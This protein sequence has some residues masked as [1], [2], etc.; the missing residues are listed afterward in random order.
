MPVV[1]ESHIGIEM[2]FFYRSYKE[3]MIFCPLFVEIKGIRELFY[4]L[5]T[6]KSLKRYKLN[7]DSR[8]VETVLAGQIEGAVSPLIV[9]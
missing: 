5:M 2:Q 7:G 9:K 4:A 1:A 3:N 6:S 8:K